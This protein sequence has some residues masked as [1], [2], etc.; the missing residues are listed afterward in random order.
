[1]RREGLNDYISHLGHTLIY[2]LTLVNRD[3]VPDDTDWSAQGRQGGTEELNDGRPLMILIVPQEAVQEAR[4]TLGRADRNRTDGRDP[5]MRIP[6][7]MDRRLPSR[8]PSAPHDGLQH[9]S[10]FIYERQVG[11]PCLCLRK[12]AGEGLHHPP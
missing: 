4:P 9:E 7:A 8:G 12:Y 10:R 11:P 5:R 1:M 6:N 3:S 2:L